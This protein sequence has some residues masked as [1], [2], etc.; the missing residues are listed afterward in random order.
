MSRSGQ[1]TTKRLAKELQDYASDPN[2]NLRFL[3]PAS[4]DDLF[5]W[6]AVMRGAKGT[7]YE[8]R[9]LQI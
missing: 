7:A 2:P 9:V 6:T 4:D 8:G 5:H 3:Q 1:S